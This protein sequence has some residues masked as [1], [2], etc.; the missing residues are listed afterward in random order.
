MFVVIGQSTS[1]WVWFYGTELKTTL[2]RGKCKPV[3]DE[4]VLPRLH[5][6]AFR[7]CRFYGRFQS[8]LRARQTI[9][10]RLVVAQHCYLR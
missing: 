9:E 8:K 3:G 5:K 1:V 6:P 10:S 4:I 2:M 7:A